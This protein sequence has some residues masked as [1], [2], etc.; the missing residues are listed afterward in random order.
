MGKNFSPLRLHHCRATERWE[1]LCEKRSVR[2]NGRATKKANFCRE[3]NPYSARRL[4]AGLERGG[5]VPSTMRKT[6]KR[7]HRKLKRGEKKTKD[8]VSQSRASDSLT[9]KKKKMEKNSFKFPE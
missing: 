7:E 8:I 2:E 4:V 9:L 1:L 5:T 3:R 6:K